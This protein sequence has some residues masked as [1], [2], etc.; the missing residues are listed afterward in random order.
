MA[1]SVAVCVKVVPDPAEISFDTVTKT[2]N[3]KDA[4]PVLNGADANALEW[5]LRLKDEH[6]AQVSV[7]SMGPPFV[8]ANLADTLAAGADAAYL[9]SDRALAESDTLPT[10][11]VLARAVQKAGG[12]DLVLAGDETS[13]SATGQVPPSIAAWLDAAQV[14]F[15]RE[16]EVDVAGGL[17]R[18][19]RELE[20]GEEVVEGTL[21]CVVSVLRGSNRP[22]YVLWERRREER[23]AAR[24]VVWGIGDLG[25]APEAVGAAGSPT[26]VARVDATPVAM[27]ETLRIRGVPAEAA[28]QLVDELEGRGALEGGT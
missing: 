25:L 22:R 1:L 13:D 19:V 6:D 26:R 9:L 7:F 10:S 28:R 27:R 2:V 20:S 3:R 16:L 17:V 23:A 11:L 21:P 8:R 12:A 18:C 24:V 14:T 5:A 4:R 15:A